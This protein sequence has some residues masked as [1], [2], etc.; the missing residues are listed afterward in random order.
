M[1]VKI[2]R[3]IKISQIGKH[4]TIL[5]IVSV[6]NIMASPRL[7]VI[8]KVQKQRAVAVCLLLNIFSQVKII[9]RSV[10]HVIADVGIFNIQ[11]T[12]KILILLQLINLL[13]SHDLGICYTFRS[14]LGIRRR[15]PLRRCRRYAYIRHVIL[16][17]KFTLR[18]VIMNISIYFIAYNACACKKHCQSNDTRNFIFNLGFRLLLFCFRNVFCVFSHSDYLR[19]IILL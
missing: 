5:L 2:V 15:G 16:G 4:G 17:K 7:R 10:Q 18:F 14:Y 9:I 12:Y 6:N 19:K 1:R 11:P 8:S 3:I 13:C